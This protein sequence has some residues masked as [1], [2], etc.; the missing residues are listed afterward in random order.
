MEDQ[1]VTDVQLVAVHRQ[2]T[3]RVSD[4]LNSV[5]LSEA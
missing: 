4:N 1:S 5:I 3:G 2:A